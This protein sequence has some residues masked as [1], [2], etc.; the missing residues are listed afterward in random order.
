MDV[1]FDSGIPPWRSVPTGSRLEEL[2][3]DIEQGKI[4][5]GTAVHKETVWDSHEFGMMLPRT[6]SNECFQNLEFEK[7]Y[8]IACGI[9]G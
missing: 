3:K 5:V 2:E 6:H 8:V 9:P 7:L 1:V 4:K